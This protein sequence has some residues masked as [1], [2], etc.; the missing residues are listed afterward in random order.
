MHFAGSVHSQC[1]IVN[2]ESIEKRRKRSPNFTI[3]QDVINFGT[4]SGFH[5]LFTTREPWKLWLTKWA[6]SSLDRVLLNKALRE[7][8]PG[9]KAPRWGV[10]KMPKISRCPNLPDFGPKTP[11]FPQELP[12]GPISFRPFKALPRSTSVAISENNRIWAHRFGNSW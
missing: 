3:S 4:V 6:T 9:I 7:M 5:E 10:G 12:S 1:Q 8:W 11:S 2:R